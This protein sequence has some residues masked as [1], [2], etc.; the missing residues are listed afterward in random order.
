MKL[1]LFTILNCKGCSAHLKEVRKLSERLEIPM[2]VVDVDNPN[3]FHMT[4]AAMRKY[5]LKS[6]PSL[7]LIDNTTKEAV[8]VSDGM[9]ISSDFVKICENF[10]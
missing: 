4:V 9:E 6:T 10:C 8:S 2:R 7:V 1:L 5:K 3:N